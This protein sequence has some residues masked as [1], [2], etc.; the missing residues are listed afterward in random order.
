MQ[1]NWLVY[2]LVRILKQKR[3]NRIRE[4]EAYFVSVTCSTKQKI[5]IG[6][7]KMFRN[8]RDLEI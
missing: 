3:L 8:I 6:N 2:E 7:I 5:L 4:R 1:L